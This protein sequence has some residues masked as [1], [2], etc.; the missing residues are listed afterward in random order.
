MQEIIIQT[1]P[2]D[3]GE[4]LHALQAN[5]IRI[6]EYAKMLLAHSRFTTAGLPDQ[7][8]LALCPVA[9]LGLGDGAVFE[10]IV[11]SANARGLGLCPVSAGVF[12]RLS[13]M[14]QPQSKNSILSGTHCSPDGAMIVMSEFLEQDDAFPKGLY[15]RNVNG[16]L[17]LR[18]YVCDAAYGWAASDVFVFA[19]A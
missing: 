16:E 7:I 17:W 3:K 4:I 2:M 6:N 19:K 12:L 1:Y 11:A 14:D 13:C 10:E 8:K 5:G 18:G 9:E 15:L